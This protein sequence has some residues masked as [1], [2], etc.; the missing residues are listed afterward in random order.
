ME[1][2]LAKQ[3]PQYSSAEVDCY[4]IS[5][6]VLEGKPIK[7]ENIST[8]LKALMIDELGVGL[9]L[10]QYRQVAI[11]LMDRHIKGSIGGG[12]DDN[13]DEGDE[14]D[15]APDAIEDLQA[16]HSS[17]TATNLSPRIISKLQEFMGTPEA[18]FKSCEQAKA[19]A[20]VLEGKHDQLVILPTGG[21][22]S[23]TFM[24]PAFI[25]QS[26]MT[27]VVLPLVSL[28]K[29][30]HRRCLEAGLATVEWN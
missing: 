25:E 4:V 13:I 7:S 3:L 21:G 12:A 5:A 6:F 30:L 8:Q 20:R 29:D 15:R 16:G 18:K 11:A 2:F 27:V 26:Y 1:V 17:K 23:L 24:L 14:G 22:K 10:S 28:A 9:T 19:V